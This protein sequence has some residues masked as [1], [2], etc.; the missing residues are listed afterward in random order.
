[1]SVPRS[2]ES[3]RSYS[4]TPCHDRLNEDI[5]GNENAILSH[6]NN[7]LNHV[8]NENENGASVDNEDNNNDE[9]KRVVA[10][11]IQNNPSHPPIERG[12]SSKFV[13]TFNHSND[14][15]ADNS[16]HLE[17]AERMDID[18][19]SIIRAVCRNV[20]GKRAKGTIGV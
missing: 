2:E 1:M 14:G 6:N 9:I 3:D 11:I 18:P 10:P 13:P 5:E 17:Y 8:D 12:S 15:N 4:P 16:R 20:T 19:P 7:I